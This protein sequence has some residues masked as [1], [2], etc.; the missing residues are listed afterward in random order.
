MAGRRYGRVEKRI[1]CRSTEWSDAESQGQDMSAQPGNRVDGES[2]MGSENSG[3]RGVGGFKDMES[4]VLRSTSRSRVSI[5][6]EVARGFE[7][8]N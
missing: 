8:V 3:C 1:N 7:T 4:H 2:R 5:A 6:N